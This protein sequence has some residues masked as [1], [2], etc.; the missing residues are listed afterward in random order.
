MV[1]KREGNIFAFSF[2]FVSEI[3]SRVLRGLRIIVPH[4][5][6]LWVSAELNVYSRV[7]ETILKVSPRSQR[8][9]PHLHRLTALINES[10]NVPMQKLVL[11]TPAM[12][13]TVT[14]FEEMLPSETQARP[15]KNSIE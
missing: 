9:Q 4:A 12:V 13:P 10:L 7:L 1:T 8:V 15:L 5:N 14:H 2:A 11:S 3:R 6:P